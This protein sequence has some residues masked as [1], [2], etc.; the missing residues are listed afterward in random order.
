MEQFMSPGQHFCA[1]LD[2][3]GAEERKF[4]EG[5]K[6]TRTEACFRNRPLVV[7]RIVD[8]K[9]EILDNLTVLDF[10]ANDEFGAT[11]EIRSQKTGT[12]I[13]VGYKP[14]RLFTY[15]VFVFLPLHAKLRWS[16]KPSA[17]LVGSLAFDLVI[18]TQSRTHLRERGMT[19]CETGVTFAQ[20]FEGLTTR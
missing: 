16:A 5:M 3:L 12:T 14:I 2:T 10:I 20:E 1:L 13:I 15:P 4:Y 9:P 17:P 7:Y 19:Y 6:N 18:R 8:R 11:C